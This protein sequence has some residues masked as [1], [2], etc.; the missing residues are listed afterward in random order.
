M[1]DNPSRSRFW[2]LF[3]KKASGEALPEELQ[4]LETLIKEHPDWA[5]PAEHLQKIWEQK[6]P[7]PDRYDAELA[8]E[9]HLNRLKESG[10][11][12]Y[13][14]N[15][16]PA[17]ALPPPRPQKKL[18]LFTTLAAACLLAI[19][20]TVY[21]F[22]MPRGNGLAANPHEVLS[23]VS[24]RMGSRTKLVLPDSSIVW[25]NAG[26][27][28]TYNKYFGVSN[29]NINL[30]GEAFYEVKKNP[31]PFIIRTKTVQI[32]ALGTA[33]NVKSYPDERT[34]E[35][36]LVR[37]KV[38]ISVDNR[39]G[40][41]FYLNPNEKLTVAS[42][43]A[44]QQPQ[45]QQ[46]PANKEPMVVLSTLTHTMDNEVIETSW[47]ENKLIFQNESFS[48]LAGKM[49]RWYG[50]SIQ[51]TDERIANQRLSGSFTTETIQQA[52]EELQITTLFH[53]TLKSNT[54]TIS[55]NKP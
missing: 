22:Y 24:T 45:Q 50:I 43:P 18:I 46:Q 37:G 32:K 27:K 8:F 26:S 55:G 54:V 23:E 39:P 14:H 4:E 12:L 7:P 16:P 41:K 10:A 5:Y 42:E 28:L 30:V 20:T 1:P 51:F 47:V 3:S 9:L 38:E 53:Y 11:D 52:L 31:I 25:L 19:A 6:E 17:P 44:Q 49:E 48:E 15:A 33:F 21:W 13:G 2:Y 40:E 35:T 34:T 29:R 36:S